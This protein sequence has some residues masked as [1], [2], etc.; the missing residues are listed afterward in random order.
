M[1]K[2]DPPCTESPT[3]SHGDRPALQETIITHRNQFEMECER[4]RIS[5]SEH[6]VEVDLGDLV[7]DVAPGGLGDLVPDAPPGQEL[8]HVEQVLLL[9]PLLRLLRRRLRRTV[10]RRRGAAT[11]GS[12]CRRRREPEGPPEQAHRPLH[13]GHREPEV[14]PGAIREGGSRK[15][16]TR[17]ELRRGGCEG[18]RR[19]PGLGFCAHRGGFSTG[20]RIL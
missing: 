13:C 9:P 2:T 18:A 5:A 10:C 20:I 15:R 17:T 14:G 19:R 8:H 6:L 16:R 1:G 12:L 11:Q 7:G 4:K 3:P